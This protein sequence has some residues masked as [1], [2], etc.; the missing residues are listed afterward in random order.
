MTV[1]GES[2]REP[3]AAADA[4]PGVVGSRARS[5]PRRRAALLVGLALGGLAVGAVGWFVDQIRIS[6][7]AWA[8]TAGIALV[9]AVA[10]VVAGLR[11]RK[12]GVDVIAVLA[13]IGT[14]A[15]GEYLAGAVVAVMLATGRLLEAAAGERAE[16]ALR[17]LQAAA[18]RSA[19]RRE[20]A[21]LHT[22]AVA[23]IAV[24]DLLVVGAGEVVPVDGRV[25]R[26]TA[27]IDE[28]TLT[29]EPVPVTKRAGDAVRSGTFNAGGPFELR[30]TT[31]AEDSAYAGIVR[32]VES[33]RADSAGSV[34]MADRYALAF[35]PA[36]L[37][38][39]ALA[40]A[41]SGQAE[42][43]VAVL[44][45]ATPCP[46]ILAVPIAIVSGLS[47]AARRGV[48]VKGGGA[49]EALGRAD[50]VLFDKTG[51]L[52]VGRPTVTD[53][54]TD[55]A[56]AAGSAPAELIRLAASLDQVSP[57]VLAAALV[58]EARERD[59][60]LTMPQDVVE[61]PGTGIRG[62]VT[63]RLVAVG[64]AAWAGAAVG[65][66]V[67]AGPGVAPVAEAG[68]RWVRTVR[69]RCTFDGSTA[70][71]VGV[72][73]RLAGA[74]LLDDPPR[75]DAPRMIN[76]LRAAGV[77]RIVMVTGDRAEVAES[78]GAGLGVDEVIAECTPA[79]KLAAV[80]AEGRTASTVMVG[81]GV[82]DA[83]ALAAATVGVALAARGTTASAE[84]ADVVL[85]VDR[86]DRLAEAMAIAARSVTIAR[87]SV[88]LG[89]GLSLIAMVVA[90][91]GGLAP[92]P[93]AL[94]QEGIDIAAIGNA[95]RALRPGRDR[96]VSLHGEQAAMSEH[97]AAE[98]HRLR[99]GLDL[100]RSAAAVA[101]D[102]EPAEILRRAGAAHRFCVEELLPHEDAEDAEFY[103]VLTSVLGGS[104]STAMMSRAHME[105]H[106]LV[107][108]LGRLLDELDPADL[109]RDDVRDLRQ[110]LYG[111]YAVLR[112]HFAQEEEDYFSLA[113]APPIPPAGQEVL[114]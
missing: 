19:R 32:L 2:S 93:G 12:A 111:L 75:P 58:R 105:I 78:V 109:D 9:P 6:A 71:F 76:R 61:E 113:D 107:R 41:L 52:T 108:R 48:I 84:A 102:A 73:G 101:D 65:A 7:V 69:R 33:A 36:A 112:L 26:D 59:L 3:A 45:V 88:L 66:A 68:G 86:L 23:E 64:T 28:S 54:V 13:L 89:M 43:A 18:P 85:T 94:L 42:R 92:A 77:G 80:R 38:L 83:P 98:H 4:Q 74:L 44:V 55:S 53:V 79:D 110:L 27:V 5:T 20:G 90:S 81:D 30:A 57:H 60:P 10:S 8:V 50:T 49:L 25:E 72:D 56:S 46:L 21:G 34:R 103:P 82:N 39:A 14:V 96:S 35:V 22:V 106:H 15:V 62:R 40:W 99:P 87:Q 16:R 24:G 17:Q 11:D 70:V 91:F 97:F 100:L 95:L 1:G 104:E 114:A 63:G 37:L 29:G 47:R 31:T 67:G 51:T